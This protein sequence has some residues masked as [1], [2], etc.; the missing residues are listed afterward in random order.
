[1]KYLKKFNES[2]ALSDIKNTCKDIL[3]E[4]SDKGVEYKIYEYKGSSLHHTH[5]KDKWRDSKDIIR[6]EI[7]NGT[8]TVKLKEFESEN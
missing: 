7:G 1:M 4:L 6:V 5:T 2:D 3:L 8:D